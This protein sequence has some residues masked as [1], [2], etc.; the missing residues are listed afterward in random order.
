MNDMKKTIVNYENPIMDVV[1]FSGDI[2]DTV[3]ASTTKIDTNSKEAAIAQ[4][5]LEEEAYQ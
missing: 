3:V 4:A 2:W 1:L 5:I